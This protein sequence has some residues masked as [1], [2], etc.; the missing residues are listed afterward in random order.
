[1]GYQTVRALI[2]IRHSGVLRIPGQT[3]G[4][5]AQDFVVEDSQATRMVGLG[6]VAA[7]GVAAA[8]EQALPASEFDVV[9][10]ATGRPSKVRRRTGGG[11]AVLGGGAGLQSLYDRPSDH[12]SYAFTREYAQVA[13]NDTL[14]L[15]AISGTGVVDMVQIIANTLE[16]GFDSRVRIYVDGETVASI[17]CELQMF[18]ALYIHN[19]T[20]AMFHVPHARVGKSQTGLQYWLKWPIP[21]SSSIR[22]EIQNTSARA[23]TF[24]CGVHYSL[25]SHSI[26]FR[27]KASTRGYANRHIGLTPAQQYDRTVKF[28]DLPAGQ[29]LSG[30]VVGFTYGASNVSSATNNNSYL[31]NNIVVYQGSQARDGSVV[32]AWNTT[33]AEDFLLNAFYFETGMGSFGDVAV[34]SRN[35]FGNGNTT[36]LV[37]L[38]SAYGGIRFHDGV[39]MTMERGLGATPGNSTVNIDL[40]Y[41][42][43]YYVGA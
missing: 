5:N 9:V 2:P 25:F 4:E 38:W 10:D 22:I 28:L 26:P 15:L 6:Y 16:G 35:M 14:E 43:L 39:L 7:L 1:M 41:L 37:D 13:I 24:Y 18:G 21:F 30:Y 27:L 42:T 40:S 17:D 12:R 34:V 31:E 36:V 29:G 20:T 33:G 23:T 19:H 8:P 3:S 32:P 11:A